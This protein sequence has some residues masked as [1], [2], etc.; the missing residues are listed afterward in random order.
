LLHPCAAPCTLVDIKREIIPP[1]AAGATVYTRASK[2]PAEYAPVMKK[3]AADVGLAWEDFTLTDNTCP[4]HPPQTPFPLSIFRKVQS[5]EAQFEKEVEKDLLSFGRGFTVVES[6][7][8][9][10]Q[11]GASQATCT[12]LRSVR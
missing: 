4:D 8:L 6:G 7:V 10:L 5:I 1:H 12:Q 2:F 11:L 3:A 9:Q